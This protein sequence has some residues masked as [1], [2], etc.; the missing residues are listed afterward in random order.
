MKKLATLLVFV[1]SILFVVSCDM[2]AILPHEHTF[3]EEYTFDAENHWYAA[4]CENEACKTETKDLAPH[5]L[6]ADGKCACGYEKPADPKP[7]DPKPE[8]PKPEDPKPE[9]H[10]HTYATEYTYDETDHWFAATCEAEEGC[11]TAIS[12]KA[13]HEFDETGACVCGLTVHV[14]T[15]A[16]EYT[17]DKTNHWF[18]A[19]CNEDG[20][21][22]DKAISGK[23]AHTFGEDNTCACGF[24]KHV[25]TYATEYTYDKTNHW[26]VATCDVEG[27]GC[28]KAISGKAAHDFGDGIAC[29]CG[30][31]KHVHSYSEEWST[32]AENHWH[33]ASCNE[34][35][36]GCDK[37][38]T[39]FGRH[40][41]DE[42]NKCSCGYTRANLGYFEDEG[43]YDFNGYKAVYATLDQT[44]V[45]KRLNG[46]MTADGNA[47]DHRMYFS[48]M[49]VTD[50]NQAIVIG[51]G[52]QWGSS[53]GPMIGCYYPTGEAYECYI[54]ESQVY[55]SKCAI[56]GSDMRSLMISFFD[57]AGTE[58]ALYNINASVNTPEATFDFF[59]NAIA[60]E[61]WVNIGI[62]YYPAEGIVKYYLNGALVST[63]EVAATEAAMSYVKL[64]AS[65]YVGSYVAFDNMYFDRAGDPLP[66]HQHKFETAWQFDADNHWHKSTCSVAADCATATDSFGAH[67]YG[68]DGFCVCGKEEAK[69]KTKLGYFDALGGYDFNNLSSSK[70]TWNALE[71][72]GIIKRLTGYMSCEVDPA[73]TTMYFNTMTVTDTNKAI[74]IG[75]ANKW[76]T[77]GGP[78]IGCYYSAGAAGGY[79]FES[80]VYFGKCTITGDVLKSLTIYFLDADG[81]TY[82]TNIVASATT[83]SPDAA[84]NV[85]GVEVAAETWV[86]VG[87]EYFPAQGVAK[88]YVNGKLATTI[89]VEA[90][91]AEMLCIALHAS[92][93][94]NSYV[95]FDNMYFGKVNPH[96]VES[97]EYYTFNDGVVPD[98]ISATFRS[99]G[100]YMDVV[101]FDSISYTEKV[102]T[103]YTAPGAQDKLF[104]PVKVTEGG[105]KLIIETKYNVIYGTKSDNAQFQLINDNEKV[106]A[107]IT[108]GYEN[109]KVIISDFYNDNDSTTTNW[110]FS[111]QTHDVA[112]G[113]WIDLRFES[114]IKDGAFQTDIYLNGELVATSTHAGFAGTQLSDITYL[115]Y[116]TFTATDANVYFDDLKVTVE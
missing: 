6:D 47:T 5:A 114:Y 88:Y 9:V 80:D 63:V 16:T 112:V 97:D 65:S 82:A 24:E 48:I 15:Y 21:G 79:V 55:F 66:P 92:Q 39:D 12:G 17:Y 116:L 107:S 19:T 49:N 10:T 46:Y 64:N 91:D 81:N 50:E 38:K 53:G 68:E 109:G 4:T 98:G 56:T 37:A 106:F 28:D 61:T 83:N 78:R 99:E 30:F 85:L 103:L 100:A 87:V 93:Y 60:A 11:A 42:D 115:R 113:S 96:L 22:C 102:L 52:N 54:F 29:A 44:G 70:T 71:S 94:A 40:D 58:H 51:T 36:E 34:E 90:T 67:E 72:P 84:Y 73:G 76:G 69:E 2:S 7:E 111:D 33:A 1:L 26:F 75:T 43:G 110:S 25:H 41:F 101:D 32:N 23:E 45:I 108:I 57:A 3:A 86:N 74:V 105:D 77:D 14:H 62:K 35:G 27:E 8:D 95:A 89:E 59:G 13:A 20:E 31:E 104:V 18:A